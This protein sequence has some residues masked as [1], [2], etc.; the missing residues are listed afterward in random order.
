MFHPFQPL[1]FSGAGCSLT[2]SG[3]VEKLDEI[4][5]HFSVF[6]NLLAEKKWF[7]FGDFHI[8]LTTLRDQLKIAAWKKIYNFHRKY[9][10]KVC[11]ENPAS[12]LLVH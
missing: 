2:I 10:Q 5:I 8:F 9:H 1:G 6:V 7:D 11:G 12:N 3:G 4:Y